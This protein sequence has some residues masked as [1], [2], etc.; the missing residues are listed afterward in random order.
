MDLSLLFTL[1]MNLYKIKPTLVLNY[2]IK[3]N[4]YGS[5][6]AKFANVPKI[7]SNITGI[8]YVFTGNTFKSKLVSY[9][10]KLLYTC[11]LCRRTK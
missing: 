4:I 1:Y 7:A 3:A 8:G 10:V 11:K 2:T 9:I 6:A 5:L